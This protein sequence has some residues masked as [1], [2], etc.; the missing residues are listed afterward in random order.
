[1]EIRPFR[2]AVPQATLDDLGERLARTRWPDEVEAAGWDYGVPLAYMRE[3]VGH[4]RERFDWR[5][6]E[7][8]IN[9]FANFRAEVDGLGIHFIHERGRGPD[10]LPLLML[11]GWPS[12]LVEML[13]LIPFLTDPG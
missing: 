9:A 5:A 7:G 2:V 3:L 8:R 4:W 1:M 10:P 6:Q 11:H 13:G 12:S